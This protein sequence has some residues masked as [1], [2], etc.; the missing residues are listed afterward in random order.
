MAVSMTPVVIGAAMN[1]PPQP[2]PSIYKKAICF[3]LGDQ[4]GRAA[5]PFEFV[6]CV[7]LEPF[8]FTVQSCRRSFSPALEKNASVL[9]SGDHAGSK[10]VL[11]PVVAILTIAAGALPDVS[12]MQVCFNVVDAVDC[13]HATCVPSGHR[14]MSSSRAVLFNSSVSCMF[15]AVNGV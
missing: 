9:E 8:A 6:I 2:A 13:T 11:S 15:S 12:R 5:Y 7:G 1:G 14:A 4:R 10:S 3:P